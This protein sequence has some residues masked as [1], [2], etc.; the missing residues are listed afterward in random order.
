LNILYLHFEI[1]KIQNILHTR[2]ENVCFMFLIS[3]L[4]KLV[5][6]EENDDQVKKVFYFTH[7]NIRDNLLI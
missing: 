3:K 1:L 2:K 4:N 7:L 5:F 6:R